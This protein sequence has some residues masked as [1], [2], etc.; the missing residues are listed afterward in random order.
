MDINA[1]YAAECLWNQ[2]CVHDDNHVNSI[3]AVI[4]HLWPQ[5]NQIYSA[6]RKNYHRNVCAKYFPSR[7]STLWASDDQNFVLFGLQVRVSSSDTS[8]FMLVACHNR[9]ESC[10]MS[11]LLSYI[12]PFSLNSKIS[13]FS[14]QPFSWHTSK[15]PISFQLK[16]GAILK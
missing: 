13:Y 10:Y 7:S 15:R 14:F 11:H 9:F 3:S 16:N 4:L 5:F 12:I 6:W 8:V 2:N 1:H